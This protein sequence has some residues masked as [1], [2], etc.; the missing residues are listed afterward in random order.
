MGRPGTLHKLP[1]QLDDC[2][3]SLVFGKNPVCANVPFKRSERDCKRVWQAGSSEQGFAKDP[4]TGLPVYDVYRAR[5]TV[6]I[7]FLNYCALSDCVL[8]LY[9]FYSI[10]FS[11]CM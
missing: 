8:K 7:R 6:F 2:N 3:L 11:N 5:G 1:F 9:L 10:V 4:R